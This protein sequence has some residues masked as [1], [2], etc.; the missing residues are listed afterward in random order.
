MCTWLD[1]AYKRGLCVLQYLFLSSTVHVMK[2]L[3]SLALLLI[4]SCSIVTCSPD[5]QATETLQS[6][7]RP[8]NI[9]FAVFA[10]GSSHTEWV[11]SIM[12]ELSE[13]GHH[14]TYLTRV[15]IHVYSNNTLYSTQISVY[16]E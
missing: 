1:G 5:Q 15:C 13:R 11:L 16:T 8:K 7:R 2:I 14:T 3:L 6:F 12:E 10:G 9:A 4:S